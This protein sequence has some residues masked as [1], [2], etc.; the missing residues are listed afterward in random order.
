MAADFAGTSASAAAATGEELQAADEL[1]ARG[2]ECLRVG[3]SAFYKVFE[4]KE[5]NCSSSSTM[6]Q[7]NDLEQAVQLFADVLQTR[8]RHFGGK[9]SSYCGLAVPWPQ[10][11]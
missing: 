3:C 10:N 8:T 4:I 1:F 6:L 5:Q 7:S 11:T 9:F 2:I